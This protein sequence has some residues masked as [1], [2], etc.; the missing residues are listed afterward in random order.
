MRIK[1][2]FYYTISLFVIT[3]LSS[4]NKSN[5]PLSVENIED[6]NVYV[7]GYSIKDG[8]LYA[9]YYKN[10]E[11]TFLEKSG[12]GPNFPSSI[13]VKNGDV[14]IGGIDLTSNPTKAILWKNNLVQRVI[15]GSIE[16]DDVLIDLSDKDIHIMCGQNNLK[17]FTYYKNEAKVATY[18]GEV[19][20]MALSGNEVY[21]CGWKKNGNQFDYS[22]LWHNGIEIALELPIESAT[23]RALDISVVFDNVYVSGFI[24]KDNINYPV[25]WKNSKVTFLPTEYSGNATSLF[26]VGKDVYAAGYSFDEPNGVP[27]A[28]YWKNGERII[29]D[30]SPKAS[31]IFD[32]AV[33][34]SGK[35]YALGNK[36]NTV[37]ATLWVDGKIDNVIDGSKQEILAYLCLEEK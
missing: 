12:T 37:N 15:E 31:Y 25:F 16:N 8:S 11:R 28:T 7:T 14:Y 5:D 27:H 23:A 29:L 24:K 20:S 6:P 21:A 9:I 36:D 17:N 22:F 33:S 26:V 34:K 32:I 2:L 1:N 4:C 18:F 35:V 13:K 10:G 19:K 3:F 30:N